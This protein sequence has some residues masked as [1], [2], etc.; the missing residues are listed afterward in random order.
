[1]KFPCLVIYLFIPYKNDYMETSACVTNNVSIEL[2]YG[3]LQKRKCMFKSQA[4][5]VTLHPKEDG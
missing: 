4:S 5:R 2:T 3:N 1:M